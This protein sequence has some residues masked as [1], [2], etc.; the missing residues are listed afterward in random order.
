MRRTGLKRESL[1]SL[2]SRYDA[3]VPRSDEGQAWEKMAPVGMEFG[4]PA[5]E[6]LM[7]ESMKD[8]KK[9]KSR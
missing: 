1:A 4:G 7:R 5:Y 9:G 3:N 2:L 8:Y 6:R